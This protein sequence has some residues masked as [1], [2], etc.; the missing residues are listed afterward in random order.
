VNKLELLSD[1]QIR[2]MIPDELVFAHRNRALNPEHP[3]I[4]GTAQNPDI[5]FQGRET[6]NTFYNNMPSIVEEVMHDFAVM[7]GRKYELFQYT[8]A[9]D[10]ERVIIIMGSGGE[11]VDETMQA[12]NA[13]GEKTGLIQVRLYRPF[14][15]THLIKALPATVKSIAILDRTKESGASGE[16]MYQ[17]VLAALVE[18]LQKGLIKKLPILV[19]GRYGLS[20]KE[21][22]P[23][24]VK[25]VYDELKKD[26]PKNGFT[27][28]INDDVTNTSL[29][30]D[31]AFTLDESAWRQ[32]LF[33]D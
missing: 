30:Y 10:A 1:E 29:S 11:T 27:I 15:L 5:Y 26:H 32:G 18:A 14:S 12:L 21:F 3:F 20:S 25:A 6:V 8:G 19:G 24:M 28:G 22:T 23:A 33:L 16:P 13:T 17:D 4:R 9:P 31:P 2:S 7:T